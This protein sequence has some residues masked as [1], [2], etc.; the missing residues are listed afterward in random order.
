VRHNPFYFGRRGDA[1]HYGELKPHARLT[2][3][4]PV[5]EHE[6]QMCARYS[7]TKEQITI[8]IGE[9]E[10][11]IKIGARY[12][13]APRQKAPVIADTGKGIKEVEMTWGWQPIWS[14]QLLINAQSETVTEK[15]TFNK[16]LHQRCLIPADGFY[17]WTADKTPIRF[18][19]PRNRAFCF[20]GLWRMVEKQELDLPTQEHS[21]VILTTKPDETVSRFHNR[22]PLIVQSRH[23]NWWLDE[24]ELFKSVIEFPENEPLEFCPVQRALNN[25]RNEG[26]ELIRPSLLQKELGF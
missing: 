6:P 1:H 26:A 5:V 3:A 16:Y 24:G 21:F 13:I 20:A 2:A 15:S 11:I 14:K 19:K 10:V 8:L 12:N 7:L 25:V 17:E 18:T 4:R 9:I 22:M 23:Y